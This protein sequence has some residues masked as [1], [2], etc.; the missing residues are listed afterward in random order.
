MPEGTIT[1]ATSFT[2]ADIS[3]LDTFQNGLGNVAAAVIPVVVDV[4]E[5]FDMVVLAGDS[6]VENGR[7]LVGAGVVVG[8][9]GGGGRIEHVSSFNE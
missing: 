3:L 1:F 9:S 5:E 4:R 7:F 2:A 6:S 8:N